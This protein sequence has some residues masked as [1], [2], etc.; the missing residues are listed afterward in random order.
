MFKSNVQSCS[1]DGNLFLNRIIVMLATVSLIVWFY[2]YRGAAM[3]A[4]CRSALFGS[5]LLAG[6]G[7]ALSQIG[8]GRIHER[9]YNTVYEAT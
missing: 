1:L 2:F 7:A 8:S 3:V 6:S 5:Q 9:L 4:Q